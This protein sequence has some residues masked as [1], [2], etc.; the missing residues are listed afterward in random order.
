[1]LLKTSAKRPTFFGFSLALH[2]DSFLQ[3]PLRLAKRSSQRRNRTGIK[4]IE[5]RKAG[6]QFSCE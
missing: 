5:E 2:L 3:F 4:P 6:L 1:M